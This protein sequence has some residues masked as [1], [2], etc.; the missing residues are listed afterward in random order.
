MEQTLVDEHIREEALE[1]YA[2]GRLGDPQAAE[3]EEHILF[4]TDC[5]EALERVDDFILAF[6]VAAKQLQA[7][8]REPVSAWMRFWKWVNLG[9][10]HLRIG[11]LA[12]AAATLAVAVA[13]IVAP[14]SIR[15]PGIEMVRLESARGEAGIAK[16]KAG[17]RLHMNLDVRGLPTLASY[18]VE[19]ADENGGLVW[20]AFVK[21]SA[22]GLSV[23]T[24]KAVSEGQY[25]LRIHG[26][27]GTLLREFGVRAAQ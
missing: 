25:W 14:V 11:M 27:D 21:P 15:E 10:D 7:E 22:Q 5:Q 2:M 18:R 4:C 9:R 20:T 16:V 6:R 26:S 17:N 24:G 19:L 3:L 1:L 12:P 13:V 8:R 23:T